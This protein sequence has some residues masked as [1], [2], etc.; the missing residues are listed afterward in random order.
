MHKV[1]PFLILVFLFQPGL[2]SAQS[3]CTSDTSNKSRAELERELE[4]CNLEIEQWTKT[5]NETKEQSA[6]YSRDVAALT[7]KINAAQANIKAKN[8]QINN[9]SKDIALKV[10]EINVLDD[11]I[12]KGRNAI[13]EILRKTNDI[14]SYSLV[15]AMLSDKD[16]SEFFVDIDTYASTEEALDNL[17]AELRADKALTEAEKAVLNKKKEAEATARAIIEAAKKEVEVANNEKKTLLAASQSAE[18][19]YASV[20][21]DR[22]AKAARIRAVLFPLANTD[23]AIPFGTALQYAEFASQKTGI[24]AAFILAILKQETGIGANTGSCVISNISSGQTRSIKTSNVFLNGI[25]PLRDLNLLQHIVT[26]LNG[27]PLSTRV[28]CPIGSVGYGGGM[29]PAQFI[30]STWACFGGYTNSL[31]GS[32]NF[33]RV[34]GRISYT[35]D[36]SY[37]AGKDVVRNALGKA[38]QSNPWT[39]QDAILASA[40]LLKGNMGTTGDKYT[41]ER[42]AACKYYSG[43]TCFVNGRAGLG[44]GY[45]NNVMSLAKSIQDDID[46]LQGN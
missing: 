2:T 40:L 42:T 30:P 46:F 24:R 23:Q 38:E 33:P 13:A 35:G 12:K 16:L 11:R 10:S 39:P 18:K 25:H 20:L 27:D 17:F 21:A 4:A 28:S 8:I 45:G 9:L 14:R 5:L 36:W 32:C 6:S 43:S 19:S 1:L 29:G 3:A 31:T 7:A 22:Q 15:E 44:L 34:G 41:D 37:N 26:D